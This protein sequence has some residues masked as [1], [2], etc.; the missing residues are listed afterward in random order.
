MIRV[1]GAPDRLI[2]SSQTSRVRVE[3]LAFEAIPG[4][5]IPFSRR[6]EI[7]TFDAADERL[8]RGWK[9]GVYDKQ[10]AICAMSLADRH[11]TQMTVPFQPNEVHPEDYMHIEGEA[12]YG[13]LLFHHFGHFLLESTTRLWWP[14][15]ES[16]KGP[17]VFQNTRLS[18]PLPDFAAR[19]FDLLGLTDQ[20]HLATQ[21][22]TFDRVVVPE[23]SFVIKGGIHESF[24]LPFV[25]AGRAAELRPSMRRGRFDGN[26]AGLYL[27]RT[28]F[29]TRRSF[30]EKRLQKIFVDAGFAVAHLEE[31]PLEQQ[32]QL[33]RRYKTI[34]GVGGSAFHNILFDETSKKTI[35]ICRDYDIN[36]NFFMIDE[37]MEND[38]T[39]I[40]NMSA[41]EA[42]KPRSDRQIFAA[43]RDEIML[44]IP[45]IEA[46]LRECGILSDSAV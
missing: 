35:A 24:R 9:A 13:G 33:V 14:L 26:Y 30:G 39:Y 40:Y 16:F 46:C 11:W 3:P 28:R 4:A 19:F 7:E 42:E 43:Y 1:F 12:V 22:L 41:S 8:F 21:S 20:I 2:A 32:I 17:I 18:Q 15:K 27:S 34:A 44:D 45:K 31:M 37:I 23:R 5:S 36:P 38:A 6:A 29:P 10:H 25:A